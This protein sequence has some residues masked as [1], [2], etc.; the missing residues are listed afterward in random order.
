MTSGSSAGSP[1]NIPLAIRQ[2]NAVLR[3][4]HRIRPGA[5]D[6]FRIRDLTE[7]S[8]TFA[9]TSRVMTNLLLVVA[10]I[11]LVVGGVGIM[12][13]MLV[14]RDRADARDRHPHGRR[15][16]RRATSCGSSSSKRWCFAWP[17]ASSGILARSRR[18][19]GHHAPV[20]LADAD[21]A[22]RHRRI[23]G[24]LLHGRHHLRILSRMESLAARSDRS[25][26]IRVRPW[27]LICRDATQNNCASDP[28]ATAH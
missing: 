13:I 19:D 26:A 21:V 28:F 7:I 15:R 11:S 16:A 14:S 1:E 3:D 2:I 9:A 5:P 10:L 23:G 6:D 27:R 22:A 8:Q 18:V 25:A 12:N 20:A 4:R 17:A 24:R